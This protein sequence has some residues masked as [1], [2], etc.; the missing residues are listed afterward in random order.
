VEYLAHTVYELK[1]YGV[2]HLWFDARESAIGFYKR[3]GFGVLGERFYKKDVP[4][5]KMDAE[6]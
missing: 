4:Y 2:E 6:L 5:F 3:F 1:M